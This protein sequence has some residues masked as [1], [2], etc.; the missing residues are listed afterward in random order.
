MK[1]T[2]KIILEIDGK[3]K[4]LSD[5]EARELCRSLMD[6]LEIKEETM[7]W[8]KYLR[9]Y[10]DNIPS[11]PWETTPKIPDPYKPRITWDDNSVR[12]CV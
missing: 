11:P 10:R 3:E 12:I 9:P 8:S 4:E 7:D 5:K 6:I 2:K 1:V